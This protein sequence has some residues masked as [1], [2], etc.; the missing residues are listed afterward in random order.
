MVP[1][2]VA[3]R[4]SPV[5]HPYTVERID[6][7]MRQFFIIFIVCIGLFWVIDVVA[8]EG[9]N[10]AGAWQELQHLGQKFSSEVNDLIGRILR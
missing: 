9:Q 7:G 2:K 6:Y 4:L 1:R 10:S 3:M 5:K 8:L